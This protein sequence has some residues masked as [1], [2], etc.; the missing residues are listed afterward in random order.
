MGLENMPKLGFGLMRLPE[1]DGVIDME[2][3]CDMV[4]AIFDEQLNRTGAGYIDF[5]LLHSLEDGPNYEKMEEYHCFEWAMEKKKQGLI[6]HFG[7]S[8]HGTPELLVKILDKHP[9]V[10]FVQI[11]LNYADWTNPIVQSGKLYQILLE[12]KIP[13]IIMEPVKG[14]TLANMAPELEKEFKEYKQNEK[15]EY[16]VSHSRFFY[17]YSFI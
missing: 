4:D 3:V 5:Y 11:Q 6:K 12:R 7:F 13:M 10:E 15:R 2:K 17:N 9:E 1:V 8:F 14:G 16:D